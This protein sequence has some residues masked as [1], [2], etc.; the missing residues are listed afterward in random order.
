VPH[1]SPSIRDEIG[2]LPR[3]TS[4]VEC[5]WECHLPD[6]AVISK[7]SGILSR[8][9]FNEWWHRA[10]S[11]KPVNTECVLCSMDLFDL[12]WPALTCQ[13]DSLDWACR[14]QLLRTARPSTWWPTRNLLVLF[15]IYQN[16]F[17]LLQ[18]EMSSWLSWPVAFLWKGFVRLVMSEEPALLHTFVLQFGG[19][20]AWGLSALCKE[21]WTTCWLWDGVC[22]IVP[23]VEF[24]VYK[25]MEARKQSQGLALRLLLIKSVQMR[26][27][28]MEASSSINTTFSRSGAS[29]HSPYVI[30]HTS[31]V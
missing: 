4:C 7:H 30:R 19:G 14:A 20:S 6:S 13:C 9:P 2:P 8:M 22:Q 1:W 18:I 25:V 24:S 16:L 23:C 26:M 27:D 3:A 15:V 10:N 29:G 11:G 17:I 31:Y 12:P 5:S 21:L 28:V